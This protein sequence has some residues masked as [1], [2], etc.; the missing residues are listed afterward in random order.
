MKKSLITSGPGQKD[1]LKFLRAFKG[2]LRCVR[3]CGHLAQLV[4]TEIKF[5]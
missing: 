5:A 2:W 3:A 4:A 1:R